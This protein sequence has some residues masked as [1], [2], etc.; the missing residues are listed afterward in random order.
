MWGWSANARNDDRI[1]DPLTILPDRVDLAGVDSYEP[2]AD[3]VAQGD[4]DL[5]G[6]PELAGRVPR[7]AVTEAGPHGS[8]DGAWD[9]AR[10]APPRAV[11]RR[12]ARST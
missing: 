6:L 1:T 10:V 12:R 9:P 3:D 4:L 5:S 2:M 7:I 11:P 8:K